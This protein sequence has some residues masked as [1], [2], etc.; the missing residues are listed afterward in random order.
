[1]FPR[2]QIN[3][4]MMT[5]KGK[6]A[7]W[8]SA[9]LNMKMPVV[10][11]QCN[12][13]WMSTLEAQYAKPAMKDLIVNDKLVSL[14]PNRL[15]SIAVFAFK[16]AVIGDYASVP[17][18]DPFYSL[19]DRHSFAA[20]LAI[21]SGVYMW[22]AAFK[23]KRQGIFRPLYHKVPTNPKRSFEMY[24]LTFGAG[25]FLFQILSFRWLTSALPTVPIIR[26]ESAW[27]KF[28][29]PF[30]PS[31]GQAVSWPP[32]KQLTWDRANEFAERWHTINFPLSWTR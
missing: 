5:D 7:N 31:D 1:M 27:N 16:Q 22:L 29:I 21:P 10:C 32:S 19:A 20:S 6:T 18:R 17:G 13:G 25:Y 26:Q 30:W 28:S 24:L 15:A 14:S 9:S 11:A 3:L 23:E 12:N 2:K 4:E 8:K